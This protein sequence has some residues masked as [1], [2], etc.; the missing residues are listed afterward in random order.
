ME[1][2]DTKKV[3]ATKLRALFHFMRRPASCAARP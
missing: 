2:Y 3:C 1:A